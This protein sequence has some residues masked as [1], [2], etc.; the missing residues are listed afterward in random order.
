MSV[1]QHW[2]PLF[3]SVTRYSIERNT[4]LGKYFYIDITSGALMTV[5]P[6]DREEFSWH[7]ITVLAMEMSKSKKSALHSEHGAIWDEAT[8][9]TYT[10]L[11]C[12]E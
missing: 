3:P 4:D 2:L 9:S 8:Y 12:F 10:P 5:L 11:V 7:N 1:T 6:L